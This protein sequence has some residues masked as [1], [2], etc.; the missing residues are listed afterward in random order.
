VLSIEQRVP[1]PI[2][3]AARAPACSLPRGP[4]PRYATLIVDLAGRDLEASVG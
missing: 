1:R 2:N 3:L 4:S